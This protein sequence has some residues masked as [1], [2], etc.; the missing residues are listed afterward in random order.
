VCFQ[1]EEA[2]LFA[3]STVWGGNAMN[4][5][6]MVAQL[7]ERIGVEKGHAELMVN[8][9]L[10]IEVV[11]SLFR[12]SAV[13]RITELTSLDRVKAELAVNEFVGAITDKP[14]LFEEVV[15]R[16]TNVAVKTNNCRDCFDCDGCGNEMFAQMGMAS[17]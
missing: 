17:R 14:A 6:E 11:P 10:A 3:P 7:S 12:R 13:E 2:V 16:F 15:D 9:I 4:K 5:N 1:S 8:E